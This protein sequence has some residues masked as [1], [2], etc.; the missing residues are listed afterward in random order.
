MGSECSISQEQENMRWGNI[1]REE[2]YFCSHLYHHF[3]G[4]ENDFIKLLDKKD[5][6]KKSLNFSK[7]QLKEDYYWE[8]GYEVCFYRDYSKFMNRDTNYSKKRTFD[9]CL[10]SQSR[11]I[12]IE[13]KA[14]GGFKK[15]DFENLGEDITAVKEIIGKQGD[16]N[17]TVNTVGICS[18]R[19][20]CR[21]TT[22]DKFDLMITWKDIYLETNDKVFQ[23]A[24]D[25]YNN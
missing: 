10:F 4:K 8:L 6:P 22:R 1:T 14:H 19:Y 21:E 24:D 5:S 2:R 7:E 13:A 15:C 3:R 11:I 12:I 23:R 16:D 18:S 25:I 9:L 20:N 17:F